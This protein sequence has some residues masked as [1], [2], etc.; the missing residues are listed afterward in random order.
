MITRHFPLGQLTPALFPIKIF[1]ISI[2]Y[3]MKGG[4]CLGG[5]EVIPKDKYLAS[6][7]PEANTL[8]SYG[9]NKPSFTACKNNILKA[10][11]EASEI[12][13]MHPTKLLLR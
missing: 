5:M 8:D 10:Y 6:V 4:L 9:V 2:L 11:R 3:I 13:H 7:L 12:Y 1:V